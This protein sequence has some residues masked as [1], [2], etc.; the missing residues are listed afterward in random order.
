MKSIFGPPIINFVNIESSVFNEYWPPFDVI[1]N[2][3]FTV[4]SRLGPCI[5]SAVNVE[6][7]GV[8]KLF[9]HHPN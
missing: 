4:N 9:C 5:L 1:P 6:P 2:I 7:K 3:N 8:L